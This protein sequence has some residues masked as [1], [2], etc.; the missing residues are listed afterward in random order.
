MTSYHL[1]QT[2]REYALGLLPDDN[3]NAISERHARWFVVL[4]SR[5]R[6]GP[7]PDGERAWIHIHDVERDNFRAG[8]EWLLVRDPPAA[9][10]PP[11][12]SSTAHHPR[13]S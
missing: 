4:G 9:L 10:T 3:Q 13:H 8:A 7:L 2:I 12:P 1:H 5:L 11:P 6:D